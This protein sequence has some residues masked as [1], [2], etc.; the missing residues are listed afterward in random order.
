MLC[1]ENSL[2]LV[3]GTTAAEGR[4]EV[5]VN[6]TWG[7]ICND[8]W[9][10]NDANVACGQLG[11]LTRGKFTHDIYTTTLSIVCYATL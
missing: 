6:E 7:T 4:V 1:E 9:S 5:C 2:R 10:T 3:G 8:G 11:F